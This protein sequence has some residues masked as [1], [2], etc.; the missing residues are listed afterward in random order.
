M[1]DTPAPASQ[2]GDTS[3]QDALLTRLPTGSPVIAGPPTRL[4]HGQFKD[5]LRDPGLRR[6]SSGTLAWGTAHQ[7][8]T[9]SQGFVLFEM[10]GSALWIAWLA[11]A[12]GIPNIIAAVIGGVL[13]DRLQ[14]RTLLIIGSSIVALPMVAIA[15]LYA[16]DALEPW[17]ILLAGSAQGVSLALDW[18]SR[19][20]LLPN[21]VPRR[22]MVS[23]I[24]I[25]QSVFNVARV[26]GPL[27]AAAILASAGPSASY[28]VIAGLFAI[29]ILIYTTFKF[30]IR[31]DDRHEVKIGLSSAFRELRETANAVR[32]DTVIGLNVLFTAMN[33]MMLGGFVFMIPVFAEEVFDSGELGLGVIFATTGTGA[34]LGAMAVASRGESISAGR[35]LMVSNLLFAGAAAVYTVTD[36]LAI[37]AIVAF[38]FGL[39]NAVHVALGIAAIQVNVP[40]RVRGRVTGAY[41][42]AWASFPLGGLVVGALA[43]AVGLQSAVAIAAAAVAVL[44]VVIFVMSPRMRGLRLDR[45]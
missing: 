15:I 17:H 1:T 3:P 6:F 22:I 14:R 29:A 4:D 35:G 44:T 8:I 32:S 12:V 11:A 45:P 7:M 41:E 2:P 28:G 40:E 25:D 42:L 36:T 16:A 9:A 10:T 5:A 31:P 43:V 34:F 24:S 20:S 13:S 38:F 30:Q 18:I 26:S 23:A 33:A 37:A 39:F 19:L 21:V 27:I